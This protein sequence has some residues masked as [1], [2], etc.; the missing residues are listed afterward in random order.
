MKEYPLRIL[1]DENI[2]VTNKKQ[3]KYMAALFVTYY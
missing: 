3:P 1:I 2:D